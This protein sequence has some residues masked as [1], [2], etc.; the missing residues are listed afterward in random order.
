MRWAAQVREIVGVSANVQQRGGF[1]DYGP[2][3]A[4][5]AIY[6]PFAQF[7]AGGLRTI[8]AGSR[9]PGS[10]AR[11][12]RRGHRAGVAPGDGRR[13]SAAAVSPVRGVDEVR[14]AALARQRLLMT[15]VGVLGGAALLLAAIGIHGLIASGV[16]ERTRELGIRMALGATVRP[17][18]S[19]AALPGIM[20]A[21]AGLVVGC[22][23]RLRRDRPD[24]QPALGRPR[25]RSDHLRR[26]RRHAARRRRGGERAPALR[27]R[28]F[29]PVALLRDRNKKIIL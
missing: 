23:A 17:G 15:L 27:V 1:Q 14:A 28:K 5:P 24:P 10:C 4:L 3:D 18:H 9:R 29:D 26:G 11:R 7:P 6:M 16:T 20:L 8:T 19:T 21:L 2:I 22:G 12:A 25:E 13:R